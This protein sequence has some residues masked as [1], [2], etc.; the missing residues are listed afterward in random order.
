M[1][2]LTWSKLVK[3]NP[4]LVVFLNIRRVVLGYA[5]L[6]F[7]AP[8]SAFLEAGSM[9]Y[10]NNFSLSDKCFLLRSSKMCFGSLPQLNQVWNPAH[11]FVT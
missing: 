7:L 9:I 3:L 8:I 5:F 10:S 1:N 2:P 6:S 4:N 11:L